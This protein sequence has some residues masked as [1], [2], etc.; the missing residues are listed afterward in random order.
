MDT[1][2]SCKNKSFFV[3]TNVSQVA[4]HR[5]S[6]PSGWLVSEPVFLLGSQSANA[7]F[8]PGGLVH[9]LP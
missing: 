9:K 2:D 6:V 4:Y 7:D 8:E 1:S 5:T 3:D